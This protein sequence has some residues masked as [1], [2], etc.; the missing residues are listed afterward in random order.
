MLHI[1][2]GTGTISFFN[3]ILLKRVMYD[4]H[5][6]AFRYYMQSYNGKVPILS[7][8]ELTQFIPLKDK[9]QIYLDILRANYS[10]LHIIRFMNCRCNANNLILIMKC[11]LGSRSLFLQSF[12]YLTQE[13]NGVDLFNPGYSITKI[14]NVV[15][16]SILP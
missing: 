16:F 12:F 9:W 10:W 4:L 3:L 7:G 6:F 14:N 5:S 1:F 15:F 2:F 8:R 11:N 13:D